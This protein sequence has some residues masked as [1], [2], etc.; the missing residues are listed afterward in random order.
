MFGALWVRA[1]S[2]QT[3]SSKIKRVSAAGST[4]LVP[5]RS[6]KRRQTLYKIT[7]NKDKPGIWE[8]D[9]V[10]RV[11]KE[12]NVKQLTNERASGGVEMRKQMSRFSLSLKPC[13]NSQGVKRQSGNDARR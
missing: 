2:Y 6:W 8:E 13:G 1:R 12:S 7:T 11:C 4:F 3:E 9:R 5:F 10:E